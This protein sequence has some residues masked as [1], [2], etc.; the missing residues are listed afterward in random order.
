MPVNLVPVDPAQLFAVPGVRIGT[1]MAGVR[2]ANRRDLVVFALDAGAAVAGVFTKNRFCAAPVQV[3]RA[4]L[5]GQA[6]QGGQS[7]IRALVINTG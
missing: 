4:H 7:H 5:A 6:D 1:A 2:K 3:C